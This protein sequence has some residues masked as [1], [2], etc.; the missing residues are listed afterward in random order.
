MIKFPCVNLQPFTVN[1]MFTYNQLS[2]MPIFRLSHT[3]YTFLLLFVPN[4]RF[5]SKRCQVIDKLPSPTHNIRKYNTIRSIH[6]TYLVC[7][8]FYYQANRC[9]CQRNIVIA[10]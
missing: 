7:A 9:H 10:Y 5:V 6:F 4:T 3:S 1:V 8:P 2:Y